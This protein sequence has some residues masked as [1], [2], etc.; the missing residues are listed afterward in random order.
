MTDPVFFRLLKNTD[1]LWKS[2][3]KSQSSTF[4]EKGKL[5][6][7]SGKGRKCWYTVFSP[8]QKY[9]PPYQR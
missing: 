6:K 5:L 4:S 9:F 3:T 2:L 8:F 7:T 1:W